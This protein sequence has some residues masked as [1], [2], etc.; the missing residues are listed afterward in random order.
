MPLVILMI[1]LQ[2]GLAVHCVRTGRESLWLYFILFV[3]LIGGV[4]YFITQVLPDLGANQKVRKTASSLRRSLDPHRTLRARKLE[5]ERSDNFDNR[6]QLASECLEVNFYA[7]AE[8]LFASCLKGMH[9]TEPSAMLGLARAQFEQGKYAATR[10]TLDDLIKA[11]PGFV[12]QE[13]HLLYA[14]SL[15]M[16]GDPGALEEYAVLVTNFSGEEARARYANLLLQTGDHDRA[17][18]VLDDITERVRL[19]PDHYA[20]SQAEWLELV[21]RLQRELVR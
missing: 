9:A 20:K 2:V 16:L 7:D 8:T 14:R 10:T 4:T 13:G 3:P 21:N 12:S 6:L 11:N 5:L 15:E 19:A 1:V 17:Q 18:R